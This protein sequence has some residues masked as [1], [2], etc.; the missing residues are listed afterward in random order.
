MFYQ[1]S[2]KICE[3]TM[4]NNKNNKNNNKKQRDTSL[5]VA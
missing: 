3:L 4:A 5:N 2:T 1:K